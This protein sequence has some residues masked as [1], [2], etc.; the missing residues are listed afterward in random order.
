LEKDNTDEKENKGMICCYQSLL[1]FGTVVLFC[2]CIA[3]WVLMFKW[4]G[5][6]GCELNQ[7]L[8]SLTIIAVIALNAM[9]IYT[10]NG[11]IFVTGIV[12]S[13]GTYLCY[14]GLQSR[15]GSSCNA[16]PNSRSTLSLW[17]GI[18]ITACALSYAGFSVS[19]STNQIMNESNKDANVSDPDQTLKV[20]VENKTTAADNS[21]D[22]EENENEK[23]KFG[24]LKL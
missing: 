20:K 8:I 18:V 17:L 5:K 7:A 11:S 1:I 4:F 6:N 2:I 21:E 19:N 15:P 9:S 24:T 12:C 14:A 3:I 10:E 13:Y 23:R 16:D 22:E